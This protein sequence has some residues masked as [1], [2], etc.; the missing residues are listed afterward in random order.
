MIL[1]VIIGIL[2]PF[3]GTALGS[4]AVFLMK[5]NRK[6]AFTDCLCG[7]A[8][9][10]MLAASVWS[11]L[12]PAIDRSVSLGGFAFMPCA[13]GFL[14]GIIVMLM[15]ERFLEDLSVVKVEEKNSFITALAVTVHNFPEGMAV[16][17]VSAALISYPDE[18]PVSAVLSLSLGI[19]IQNIP[20]GAIVS[21]PMYSDKRG[22]LKAF[23]YGVLSGA[24]E[25]I[26]AVMTFFLASLFTPLMPYFLS[27]AAGTMI[28][29]V[30]NELSGEMQTEKGKGRGMLFFALGFVI[31][32]SLDVALG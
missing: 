6:Q 32:M 26:G 29:V 1:T 11:L 22:K 25:P 3:I 15:G 24:V 2:L 12:L 14:L 5:R 17:L 16:G 27:F 10:V 28:F 9:G 4:S 19:A 13:V 21:L 7:F 23:L 18:V 31:M 8:G 20:E 30:M